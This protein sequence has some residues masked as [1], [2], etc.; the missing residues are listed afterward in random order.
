M[1]QVK[2]RGLKRVDWFYR[3]TITAYNLLRMR[4]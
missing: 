3:L 2:L 1:R 4:D